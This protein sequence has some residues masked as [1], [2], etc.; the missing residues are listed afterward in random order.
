MRMLEEE[1]TVVGDTGSNKIVI[2]TSPRYMTSVLEIVKELDASPPQVMIQVLLAEVTIDGRDEWGMDFQV[3]P[4]G[5]EGY[6]ISSAA[7]GSGVTTAIGVPNL[8]VTSADFGVLIRALESQG[9]LEVLS[10]PQVM[11]NNNQPAEIKVVDE[12]GVAGDT[13][14]SGNNNLISGVTRLDAGIILNV[15]PS[16]SADGFVRMEIKPEISALTSRTT[17]INA[18]QTSPIISRRTIDTVVTVKDGQSVVIGGLIQTSE[19]T[20]RT[21]VPII[22]DIPVIGIPFNSTED[23]TRKTELMV[24]L[25]PRVIPGQS[26]DQDKLIRD[27]T[28]QSVDRLED[29]TKIQDY[30][31]RIKSEV[32]RKRATESAG[33]PAQLQIPVQGLGTLITPTSDPSS[34][35][36][37]APASP[38]P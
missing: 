34:T 35:P 37:T 31:E 4:F 10:N 36:V 17:Q 20:R 30:L 16:I 18:D 26:E 38:T 24:I 2:S 15:T 25:T 14:R 5:G 8:A 13:E 12:I 11:V 1:V 32:R 33:T 28:E 9:K 6:E 21:K 7:A 27:V 29:P 22:G 23:E 19:E 3:G